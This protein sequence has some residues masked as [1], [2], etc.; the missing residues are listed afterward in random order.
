[1]SVGWEVLLP[2]RVFR[3]FNLP[4]NYVAYSER[5]RDDLVDRCLSRAGRVR[6]DI[7]IYVIFHTFWLSRLVL[8]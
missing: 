7:Y 3:L 4:Q 8:N 2:L 1:M 6:V 5:A